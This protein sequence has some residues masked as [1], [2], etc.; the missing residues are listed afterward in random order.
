MKRAFVF[1][2]CIFCGTIVTIALGVMKSPSLSLIDVDTLIASV[3][4]TESSTPEALKAKYS[5]AAGGGEKV[6]VLIVPGHD[7]E[8]WG[9][10]FREVRE[11]D[12]TVLLGEEL[13]RSLSANP[14][15]QPIL[16]RAQTGYAP[17]FT[18]YIE[19]ERDAIR[20]FI[21]GKKKIMR[22][23]IWAGSAHT[24]EGV[25]HGVA[26]SEVAERLY[27]INR[28]AN[29]YKIDIVLH[30]HFNDYP[31]RRNGRPGRYSGFSFY[32]PDPQFSNARASRAVAKSLFEQFSKFHSE[33]NLPIEN[34]GIV[35]DQ[36][37]IAVGAYNT[38]DPASVLIEYGYIYE[39][40]F[41]D[42]E[43]REAAIKEL[44]FQTVQGLNRFFGNYG[45]VFQ[46]YPT[47][48]LPH[49][50]KESL[51]QGM[52]S[53][54]SVL[55]LQAALLLEGLYP[56]EGESKRD[57]PLSGNFGPCTERAVK[58]FQKKN[59]LSPSG[60]VGELTLLELNEKYS[61]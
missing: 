2:L 9:T 13:T 27:A 52:G 42:A 61:K 26:T 28:W 59:G 29:E 45:E 14:L 17:G 32:V 21:N 51:V 56:P 47:A 23:L 44:A 37:L 4:F 8:S 1:L 57:C 10:E 33:S 35:E 41:L 3:F 40:R 12:M 5:V 30:I 20:A 22:D 24:R 53:H 38:L 6:R 50:W 60:K 18:E 25:M 48:L 36:E 19:K 49:V 39:Q 7:D 54:P 43:V 34:S 15:Y 58:S 31:G 46:K 11:A 55:S 16:V